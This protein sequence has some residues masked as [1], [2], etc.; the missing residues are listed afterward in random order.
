[1]VVYCHTCY[2]A[3]LI[4]SWYADS[5]NR[6]PSSFSPLRWIMLGVTAKSRF[7][8]FSMVAASFSASCFFFSRLPVQCAPF[9][10]YITRCL[11]APSP[12]NCLALVCSPSSSIQI[13]LYRALLFA[14]RNS[15][16]R[17]TVL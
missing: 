15:V 1:M 2:L 10:I 9:S 8:N 14:S 16:I 4:I 6:A 5:A 17:D 7:L 11:S 12:S 13:N 3:S